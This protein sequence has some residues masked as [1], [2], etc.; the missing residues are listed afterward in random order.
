MRNIIMSVI[1]ALMFFIIVPCEARGE[2]HEIKTCTQYQKEKLSYALSDIDFVGV[3]GMNIEKLKFTLHRA[4]YK[5][6]IEVFGNIPEY[7]KY[8]LD[9]MF[10]TKS[11]KLSTIPCSLKWDSTDSYLFYFFT[12]RGKK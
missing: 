11:G 4:E 12:Y 2:A 5:D 7:R 6:G 10:D 3:T 9:S 1:F 8:E